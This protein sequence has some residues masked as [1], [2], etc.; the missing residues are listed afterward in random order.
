[1]QRAQAQAIKISK[2]VNAAA[3]RHTAFEV[4]QKLDAARL[5]FI[6]QIA[7]R[8]DHLDHALR[9]RRLFEK[10]I[11]LIERRFQ[12]TSGV[13]RMGV[14][15]AADRVNRHVDA[16]ANQTWRDRIADR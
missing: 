4:Q 13:L 14:G 11:D 12:I 3:Q 8:L 15:I 1:L 7:A 9:A 10:L 6:G 16:I 5:D 2:I